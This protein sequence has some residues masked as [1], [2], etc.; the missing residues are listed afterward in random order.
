M[1]CLGF[2]ALACSMTQLQIAGAFT[3]RFVSNTTEGTPFAKLV[4]SWTDTPLAEDMMWAND[5]KIEDEDR[6][7]ILRRL[8]ADIDVQLTFDN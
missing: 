7:L 6:E 8:F 2:L 5:A 3:P 4:S 1:C